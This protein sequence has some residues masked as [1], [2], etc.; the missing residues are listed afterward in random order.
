MGITFR[1]VDTTLDREVALKTIDPRQHGIDRA[2]ERF[3]REARAAG[4]LRHRN[5]ATIH[6]CGV[7]EST[8]Q[9]FYAMELV[10]GETLEERVRRTGPLKSGAV[11]AIAKQ[12]IAA[13][14]AAE[15]C[16]VV[17]RDLKPSNIMLVAKRGDE[18]EVKIIDFGLARAIKRTADAMTITHSGFVGTPAFASPE[19]FTSGPVDVRSDIF[20]LGATLWF[21]LTGKTPFSGGSVEEIQAAQ[22]TASLPVEQLQAAHVP[23]RFVTLIRSMLALEPAARP[24]TNDIAM[25][26]QL[27]GKSNV[28]SIA[29]LMAAAL[30]LVGVLLFLASPSRDERLLSATSNPAARE[31]FLKGRYFWN[32]RSGPEFQTAKAY[33]E[34]AIAIDPNYAQAYVGLADTYQFIANGNRQVRD[35]Y[36]GKAKQMIRR[37]LELDPNLAE[38]HAS[39][40]LLVMNYHWDWATAEREFKQAIALNPNYAT[41][42]QWYAA[43][44]DSQ[45]RF[46]EAIYQIESARQ[47]E[48]LSGSINADAAQQL[49]FAG[50]FGEAEEKAK[51]M[52]KLDPGFAQARFY[53]GSVY[54]LEKRYDEAITEL[55]ML[56]RAEIGESTNGTLWRGSLG[57]IYA[58]AG[59][60]EQAEQMLDQ[61]EKNYAAD[62]TMDHAS[63]IF[64]Y[65]GLGRKD[66]AFAS[67]EDEYRTRST[68]MTSLK[69]HPLF[70]SLRSDPRYADLLRRVHLG[71]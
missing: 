22:R 57:M 12:V 46:D 25:R 65:I 23:S 33:F 51:E 17:H 47:L 38:A 44:L 67:L 36:Y 52:L 11:M 63:E 68:T 3:M 37:A 41:A 55:K 28:Q 16:G 71:P 35:E 49:M 5:V 6:H 64:I 26:L 31:A 69:V 60:K 13:L 21:A 62:P 66:E 30:L 29:I 39:L 1:A 14:A 59:R 7:H 27:L 50:R 70:A 20:S 45:G 58:L 8:G 34:K 42:H 19:Q 4:K 53:L 9:Y 24:G 54:A 18:L 32:K 48:P 10:E 61:V 2:R 43:Y 15:E 56:E 40:G